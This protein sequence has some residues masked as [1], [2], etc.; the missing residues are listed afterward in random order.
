MDATEV[1]SKKQPIQLS[2]KFFKTFQALAAIEP[3]ISNIIAI[4]ICLGVLMLLKFPEM[5]PHLGKYYKYCIY[6]AEGLAAYQIIKSSSK[7]L[8][9]PVT[10]IMVASMGVLM[11]VYITKLPYINI[12]TWRDI[13]MVGIVGVGLS[14][15]FIP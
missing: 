13:A 8:C 6:A 7:S 11:D 1:L 10:A 9:L 14:V 4:A 15:F 3:V 5:L 2:Y 12:S